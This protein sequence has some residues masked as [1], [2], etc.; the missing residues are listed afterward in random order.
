MFPLRPYIHTYI[1]YI[2]TYIPNCCC[3]VLCLRQS[4]TEMS[5]F[6]KLLVRIVLVL[7]GISSVLCIILMIYL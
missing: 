7:T 1:T 2:H 3:V 4:T 6:Q 5:N